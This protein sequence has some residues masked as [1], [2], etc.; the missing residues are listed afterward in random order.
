MAGAD[1]PSRRPPQSGRLPQ[2][3]GE[4]CEEVLQVLAQTGRLD[5]LR[6]EA[7]EALRTHALQRRIRAL[8]QQR[9]MAEPNKKR[10]FDSL[11]RS[12][13]ALPPLVEEA[14][15]LLWEV[16]STGRVAEALDL[17]AHEALCEL[18][19]AAQQRQLAGGPGTQ[20]PPLKPQQPQQPLTQQ[21]QPR[22][23]RLQ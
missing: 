20:Q 22:P 17:A 10:L 2:Q 14:Q 16:L 7:M 5:A 15:R 6:A 1:S 18:A 21:L 19:E 11:K 9:G 13:E 3:P 4:L 12:S 8:V 23:R